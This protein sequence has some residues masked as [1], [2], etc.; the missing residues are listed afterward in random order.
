MIPDSAVSSPVAATRTRSEPPAA[1]VPA[2][3]VSPGSL[4]TALDSPVIIDSSTSAL[5]SV[6]APSTGTRAP[7]TDEDD[8]ADGEG[9]DR[10]FLGAVAVTRS[11]VS[12][13]SSASA[14]RAPRAW[15]MERISSQWPSSMIVISVASS[16]Q[17]ST[18]NS[19]SVPAHE[20]TNATTIASEIRVIIPGLPV[21]QLALRRRG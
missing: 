20:V 11:A 2:T 4:A 9:A 6:T 15:A 19:P 12:G 7:G 5:P 3:T 21:G 8:V 14:A 16:H 13:S 17:I 18:S 1:T 10:D